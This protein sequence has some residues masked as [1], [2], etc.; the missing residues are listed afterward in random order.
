MI[1]LLGG[2]VAGYGKTSLRLAG[3][4]VTAVGEP[5]APGDLVVELHGD[6]VLPGLINAHD[7]LQ[8]NNFPRLK[9]RQTHRNVAE[10]IAD[11][12]AHRQ[13]DERLIEP[14]GVAREARLWHGGIK[15]LM[16]GVTTVVHHDPLYPAL[17]APDFPVRVLADYG[18]SHSLD[19]DGEDAVR[20]SH[21]STPGNWP[22]FIHAG[23]GI[24]D[25][26]AAEFAVLESLGCVSANARFIHGVAFD[27]RA[28]A[29]LAEVRAGLI[30]CP[31]SNLFLFGRTAAVGELAALG[32]IALGSDS[33]LSGSS[34][35]LAEVRAAHA[36]GLVPEAL[37]ETL[38]T[39]ASA[40]LLQLPDRGLLREGSLADI[41]ILPRDMPLWK[42]SCGD[43]RCVMK[44]GVMAFGDPEYARQL[45]GDGLGTDVTV[46]GRRKVL[47]RA[48]AEFR[49]AA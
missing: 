24:D 16:S 47:A 38:V 25:E 18:W 46:D 30:W 29:R 15:N 1:T 43:L 6:R 39:T 35:L 49:V 2:D 10:W 32:R 21:R 19:I 33:R 3:G 28:C 17:R 23:E 45:L 48:L 20:R 12:A 22:W 8:L 5:P 36:L 7:H 14:H 27:A 41:V 26:A 11:I 4:R 31:A 42:A 37:I 9:Y 44:G 34:D 13:S 40:S